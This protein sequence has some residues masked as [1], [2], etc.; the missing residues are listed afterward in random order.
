[1]PM[2]YQAFR[3]ATTVVLFVALAGCA[4]LQGPTG[5]SPREQGMTAYE[6]GDY[7]RAAGTLRD[8]LEGAPDDVEAWYRLG[9]AEARRDRLSAALSAYDEVLE[10]DAGHSRA[11]YN[12]GLAQ[13]RL[14]IEGIRRASA[15]GDLD[16][17][18][19]AS[20]LAYLR[21]LVASLDAGAPPAG[22]P[23]GGQPERTQDDDA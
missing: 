5:P 7:E 17:G 21:C 12:R 23:G 18:T 4:N 13:V 11:R 16:P 6:A 10:R 19:R 9:N 14:G 22:C 3:R 2:I 15:N 1:M 20:T 8:Y